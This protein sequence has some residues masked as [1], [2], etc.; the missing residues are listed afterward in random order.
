MQKSINIIGAGRVARPIAAILQQH[1]HYHI[2]AVYSRG[3]ESAAALAARIGSQALPKLAQLPRADI[4]LIGTPDAAI[5][6]TAQALAKLPWLDSDTLFIH[7]S[8]AK[9]IAELAPL[10]QRGA[11]T[12]GLHPVFAFADMEHSL[13]TL[14]GSLCALEAN[15][16]ALAQLQ[17]MA[18][19]LGLRGFVVEPAKKARYHAALS[20]AANFSVALAA[21]AQK[22]LPDSL[23][24]RLRQE[25]V[26]SLMLQNAGN[27]MR[28]T[29]LEALTGPI[30]RGDAA[31]VAMHLQ[32]MTPTEQ[33]DYRA[34]AWPTLALAQPRLTPNEV[35]RL[36]AL[37]S[38]KPNPCSD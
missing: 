7:F 1:P 36:Q 18:A 35:R 11:Q 17:A 14:S 12:G 23:D 5:A 33:A 38:D 30:V 34:W 27:L 10:A 9:T 19:A 32:A 15:G 29:P 25:L 24:G 13:R 21:Y 31:T 6:E 2:Q 28:Q 4:T 22:L 26:A 16:V 3:F 8:G 37:L 20:A